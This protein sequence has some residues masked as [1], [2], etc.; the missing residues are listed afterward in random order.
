MKRILRATNYP[1]LYELSLCNIEGQSAID[2]FSDETLF[3]CTLK[4]RISSLVIGISGNEARRSTREVNAL[5]FMHVCNTFTNIRYIDFSP[6]SIWYQ[7]LIFF[8]ISLPTVV[9]STL[10]ELHAYLDT[11]TDCLYLLDEQFNQLHTLDVNIDVILSSRFTNN[12]Q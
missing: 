9:S 11:F 6:S 3:T 2:L 10:L 7:R 5:L 12:N 8:G 1:N 4:N